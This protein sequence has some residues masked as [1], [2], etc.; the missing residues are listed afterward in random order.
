MMHNNNNIRPSNRLQHS[1]RLDG[2]H[3]P[4][5]GIAD[6]GDSYLHRQSDQTQ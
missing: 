3:R 5:S 1:K 2:I 4:P 6:H